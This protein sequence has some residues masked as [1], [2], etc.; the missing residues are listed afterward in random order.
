MKFVK[1]GYNLWRKDTRIISVTKICLEAQT[2]SVLYHKVE[3][4]RPCAVR[5]V[6]TYFTC[7]LCVLV[8]LSSLFKKFHAFQQLNKI[9]KAIACFLGPNNT[10]VYPLVRCCTV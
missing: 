9:T 1:D 8:Q 10:L 6:L 7:M 2:L 5:V 4:I 3:K